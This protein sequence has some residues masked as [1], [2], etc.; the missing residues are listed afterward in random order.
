MY[1]YH[2]S[3]N[4]W[5]AAFVSSHISNRPLRGEALRNVLPEPPAKPQDQA[6]GVISGWIQKSTFGGQPPFGM[7]PKPC[8]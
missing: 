5:V 3:K 4:Q 8:K 2:S 6:S 7:V 1:H